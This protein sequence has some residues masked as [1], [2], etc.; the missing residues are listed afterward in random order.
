MLMCVRGSVS[1]DCSARGRA[2]ASAP[3]PARC[4]PTRWWWR[5]VA[6]T[7][8]NAMPRPSDCPPACCN[9]M[10]ATIAT[11]TSC[12]KGRCWWLAA[13][14]L[15]PKLPKTSFLPVAASISASVRRRARPAG[16]AA[17]M[18]SIGWSAWAI[19][20]CRSTNMPTPRPCGPR[21]TTTSADGMAATTSTCAA[22]P[23][24]ACNCMGAC[25]S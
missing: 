23:S 9:L 10:P 8:P 19:T 17:G 11:P 3:V 16:I 18:W 20:P 21:P 2:I 6:I 24:M 14:S 5:L 25:W 7:T 22:M 1:R 12:L 13:A 4:M 15:A